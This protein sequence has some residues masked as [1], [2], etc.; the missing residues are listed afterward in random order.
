MQSV[1]TKGSLWL[2]LVVAFAVA[3]CAGV[4][5]DSMPQDI[6]QLR[7][8]VDALNLAVH[9]GRGES[10]T[11]LGQM[12][13]RFREQSAENTRQTAALNAKLEQ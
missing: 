9:R 5:D 12:E 13:R 6:A 10:D 11:V 2:P 1:T 4:A 7:K 3:G 8:D